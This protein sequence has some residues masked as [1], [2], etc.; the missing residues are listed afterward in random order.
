MASFEA[1]RIKEAI[2]AFEAELQVNDENSE[3]WRMLG[4]CHAENDEVYICIY[5]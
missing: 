1:G 3:A 2:L 4:L 5:L